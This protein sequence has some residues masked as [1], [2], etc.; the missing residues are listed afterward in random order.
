MVL[1]LLWNLGPSIC[2][3]PDEQ[4]DHLEPSLSVF[5]MLGMGIHV[6][7]LLPTAFH[8]FP[9]PRAAGVVGRTL[10]PWCVRS[11]PGLW[12]CPLPFLA[13]STP[14]DPRLGASPSSSPGPSLGGFLPFPVPSPPSPSCPRIIKALRALLPPRPPSCP[15]P[16]ASHGKREE[17]TIKVEVCLYPGPGQPIISPSIWC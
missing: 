10:G 4:P 16:P 17:G 2:L 1:G 7:A 5:G 8:L 12:A 3:T 14:R 13:F 6:T 11:Q 15:P 9:L